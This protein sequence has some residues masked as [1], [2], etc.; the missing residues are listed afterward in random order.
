MMI[1]LFSHYR[2]K[3]GAMLSKW[4]CYA[5]PNAIFY[6]VILVE[7]PNYDDGLVS[8]WTYNSR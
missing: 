3:K 7:K 4:R 5:V 2:V 8:I 1:T 6:V